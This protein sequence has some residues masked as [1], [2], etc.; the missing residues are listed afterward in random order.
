MVLL[1]LGWCFST[2]ILLR[3]MPEPVQNAH[4][5]PGDQGPPRATPAHARRRVLQ[6][7]SHNSRFVDEELQIPRIT[8]PIALHIAQAA[9]ETAPDFAAAAYLRDA[10][11]QVDVALRIAGE[12]EDPTE[13]PE[14]DEETVTIHCNLQ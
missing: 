12:Q 10:S 2:P 1:L 7:D 3:Q 8:N 5:L 6:R 14:E 4:L 13:S 9:R 11:L